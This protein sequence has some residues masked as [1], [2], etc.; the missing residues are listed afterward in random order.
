MV[1]GVQEQTLDATFSIVQSVDQRL[2]FGSF[3]LRDVKVHGV[4]GSILELAQLH[5]KTCISRK[6][7]QNS[8]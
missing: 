3:L 1:G 5:L 7:N 6:R 4:L 2:G 8:D